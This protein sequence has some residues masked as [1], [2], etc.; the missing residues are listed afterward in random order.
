MEDIIN[1]EKMS[2]ILLFYR[3]II[4]NFFLERLFLSFKIFLFQF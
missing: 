4:F 1:D 2:N 3:T